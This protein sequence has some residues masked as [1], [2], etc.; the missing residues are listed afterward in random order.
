M[1]QFQFSGYHNI[2]RTTDIY[3]YQREHHHLTDKRPSLSAK[4][5]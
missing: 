1:K 3:R 5:V 4:I 2:E